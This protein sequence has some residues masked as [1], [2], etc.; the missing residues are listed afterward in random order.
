ML[1]R[2][3][4][5]ALATVPDALRDGLIFWILDRVG[6]VPSHNFRR[7]VYAKFGMKF[8]AGAHVY[9]GLE[10]REP[11]R[12]SLGAN[13]IVGHDVI[14]D[15]RGGL[16][17]GD[18][19]NVSSQTAIWTMT[20]DPQSST[21]AATTA[22]VTI[23][24]NAWLGFRCTILPGVEVGEGAIVASGAVVTK[25]VAPFAIVAGVPARQVGTRA[26]PIDY[27]LGTGNHLAFV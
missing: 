27:D 25:A 11:H 20:H 18:N 1:K 8:G 24:R 3:A 21:F 6:R 22:P 26:C 5:A 15:G 23:G 16:L 7:A 14:L 2:I 4:G 10:I 17:I 13:A 19:V 9:G 12:V